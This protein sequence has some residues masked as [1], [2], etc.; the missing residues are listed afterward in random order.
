[1]GDREIDHNA[2]S[3]DKR[4]HERAGG[5]TW[6]EP[7]SAKDQRQHRTNERAPQADAATDWAITTASRQRNFVGKRISVSGGKR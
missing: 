3:V 2:G 6:I 7:Q 5:V 4:R 1:V